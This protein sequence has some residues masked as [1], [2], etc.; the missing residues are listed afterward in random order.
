MSEQAPNR[1]AAM[2]PTAPAETRTAK[3]EV[4]ELLREMPDNSTL[5]EIM[6]ELYVWEKLK[7]SEQDSREGRVYTHE[8]MKE[9]LKQ[10]LTP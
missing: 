8:E 2:S 3:E 1:E 6:Y 7:I 9:Q 5:E 4:M 10:W